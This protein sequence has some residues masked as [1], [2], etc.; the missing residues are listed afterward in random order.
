MQ[1]KKIIC[2]QNY[3]YKKLIRNGEA[4][5][6]R[7][8]DSCNAVYFP[9]IFLRDKQIIR[10]ICVLSFELGASFPLSEDLVSSVCGVS[11]CLLS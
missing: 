10:Q 3:F 4:K 9:E 8:K 1:D 11:V 7:E 6:N 5:K 2:I